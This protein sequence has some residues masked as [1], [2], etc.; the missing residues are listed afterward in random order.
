MAEDG[1]D[2]MRGMGETREEEGPDGHP[3]VDG[4]RGDRGGPGVGRGEGEVRP[5]VPSEEESEMRGMGETRTE[6]YLERIARA[7]ERIA[8]ALEEDEKDGR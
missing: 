8:E 4:L 5:G 7:L 3:R 1:G 6:E 2:G